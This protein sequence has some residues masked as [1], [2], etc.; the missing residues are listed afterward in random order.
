MINSTQKQE[1]EKHEKQRDLFG[2]INDAFRVFAR[3]S[4]IVLGSAWAF[5]IAILIIA[6]DDDFRCQQN[7]Q[8]I[9][10]KEFAEVVTDLA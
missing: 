1:L 4:S 2:V 10:V 3:Q 8:Q 5:A 6:S 7:C 9:A